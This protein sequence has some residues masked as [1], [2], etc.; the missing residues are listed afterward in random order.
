MFFEEE[1]DELPTFSLPIQPPIKEQ[2]YEEFL[3][4][5]C[6]FKKEE[7]RGKGKNIGGLLLELFPGDEKLREHLSSYHSRL[8]YVIC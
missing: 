8:F 7:L 1:P 5:T 2:L 6:G 4:D 3:V